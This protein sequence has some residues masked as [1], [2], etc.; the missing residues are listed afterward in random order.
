MRALKVGARLKWGGRVVTAIAPP[1]GTGKPFVITTVDR[2]GQEWRH[3]WMGDV[4]VVVTRGDDVD[5]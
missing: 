3:R 2:G 1:T 4:A 5:R